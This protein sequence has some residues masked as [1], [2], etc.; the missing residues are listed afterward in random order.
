LAALTLRETYSG[1]SAH[2]CSA[3]YG[4]QRVGAPSSIRLQ[5]CDGGWNVTSGVPVLPYTAGDCELLK[6]RALS[7]HSEDPELFLTTLSQM[8]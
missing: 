5:P 7:A 4:G 2:A 6:E 8:A 3:A 1:K